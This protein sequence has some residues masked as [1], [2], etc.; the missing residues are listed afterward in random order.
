[1]AELIVYNI[2]DVRTPQEFAQASIPKAKNIDV[3]QDSFE[4]ELN[5]LEKDKALFIYCKAGG[6]SEK[7][8]KKA[9]KMGFKRIIELDGGFD[10]WK[11]SKIETQHSM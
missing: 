5:K 8:V 6:R 4:E 7:A 2:V 3:N 9:K 11:K 1:M 10:E